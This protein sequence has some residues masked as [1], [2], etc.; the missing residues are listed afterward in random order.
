LY[1]NLILE[2][3][4][5]DIELGSVLDLVQQVGIIHLVVFVRFVLSEPAPEAP[6]ISVN[7]NMK[8]VQVVK[9][10]GLTC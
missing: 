3:K 4:I 7:L 2:L 8:D 6:K 5:L 9:R 10:K 1:R